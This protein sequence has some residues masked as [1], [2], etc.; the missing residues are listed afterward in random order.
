MIG[1]LKG[2]VINLSNNYLIL[3]V[4]GVGYKIY[5][6]S[7]QLPVL[8]SQIEFYIHH[9]IREDIND[10]YGFET[11]EE[12]EFFQLL[13]GVPGV[14]P[15]VAMTIM[16]ATTSDKLRDSIIKSDAAVLTAIG[17][18]GQKLA[19]KIIVE[20]KSK[21]VRGGKIDVSRFNEASQDFID[22]L[23]SLGYNRAEV[24]NLLSSMPSD[25]K[26]I[27]SQITWALKHLNGKS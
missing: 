5:L 14:G 4:G 1:W 18:V 6:A 26:T 3:D 10:L 9:H 27:Q 17:G 8:N 23:T 12:L 24:N 13:L 16:A 21:I 19:A 2:K 15:K 25:K 7:S 11:P 20:L 22:A